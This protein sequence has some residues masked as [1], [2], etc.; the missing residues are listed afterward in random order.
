MFDTQSGAQ[1]ASMDCVGDA[2]DLFY[3]QSARRIYVC[4]GEGAVDVVTQV[5]ADHYQ[6][7]ATVKTAPGARTAG[8]V[9][10]DRR[11]Y[12]AVPHRGSQSAEL[13][14]FETVAP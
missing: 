14:V 8:F 5:D 10:S 7:V 1:V 6:R 9:P 12:V 3:D 13:R 2:D 4:G 11:L